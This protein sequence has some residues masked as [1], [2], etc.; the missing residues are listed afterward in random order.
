LKSSRYQDIR[1]KI[2]SWKGFEIEHLLKGQIE[3]RMLGILIER[4]F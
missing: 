3:H 2:L 4:E 1:S